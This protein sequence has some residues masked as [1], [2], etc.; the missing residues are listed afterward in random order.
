MF[1]QQELQILLG[2]ANTPIDVNDLRRNTVYGGS[3]NDDEPTI[4]AFWKVRTGREKPFSPVCS[5]FWDESPFFLFQVVEGF[6]A[7]QRQA[8]L[9]FVT[10][11]GRPPLLYVSSYTIFWELKRAPSRSGFSGL[12]PKFSIRSAGE[13]QNRLPTASTCVNLLKV[14]FRSK[15]D[16]LS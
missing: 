14:P 16:P 12:V 13:D 5:F 6:N 8:L 9:R 15:S 10:S 1:N 11:V 2:G 3:F 4:L 7:E